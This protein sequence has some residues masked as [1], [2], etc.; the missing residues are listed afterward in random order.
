MRP[1]P[2]A[3]ADRAEVLPADAGADRLARGAV[4]DDDRRALI[5]DADR[6]DRAG[7]VERG[8]GDVEGR[9]AP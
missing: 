3:L 8:G 6:V 4:P 7:G 5:G 2:E 1:Q 9:G